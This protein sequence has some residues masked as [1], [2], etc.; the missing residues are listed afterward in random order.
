MSWWGS[1]EVKYG[2]HRVI[3]SVFFYHHCHL[4]ET[5]RSYKLPE[6][7]A[8][9][10]ICTISRCE[11]VSDTGS[12]TSASPK[13]CE[14]FSKPSVI[15]LY[16]L[17]KNGIPSSWTMVPNSYGVVSP[18]QKR[19]N[20]NQVTMIISIISPCLGWF[21]PY[22]PKRNPCFIPIIKA[23]DSS[24]KVM[25]PSQAKPPFTLPSACKKSGAGNPMVGG[26]DC[27]WYSRWV[28]RRENPVFIDHIMLTIL[29]AIY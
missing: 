9:S 13:S 27:R 21:K 7:L 24:T 25:P 1:H 22:K 15:P 5:Q 17:I 16:C 18:D 28:T 29:W 2:D 12:S 20:I 3:G 4:I 19:R 26:H 23:Q 6:E 14:H 8:S 10:G 11:C